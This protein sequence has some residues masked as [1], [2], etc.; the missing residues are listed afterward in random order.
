MIRSNGVMYISA[1]VL[2]YQCMCPS[3]VSLVHS[4]S[5]CGS[6]PTYRI[7]QGAIFSMWNISIVFSI[8]SYV[9]CVHLSLVC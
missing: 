2:R 7:Q 4:A 5:Q 1:C 3:F 8:V 9:C 6:A